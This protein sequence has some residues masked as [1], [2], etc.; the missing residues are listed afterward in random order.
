MARSKKFGSLFGN[1]SGTRTW[2]LIASLAILL[3]L[4]VYATMGIFSR[5]QADDYCYAWNGTA[6]PFMNAQATWYRTDSSRY[7]ATMVITLSEKLGRWTVPALPAFVLTLWLIGSTWLIHRLQRILNLAFPCI[8]SFVLAELC[9]Y[10]VLLLV[11]NLYQVLYWRPGLV[12]YL[13]PIVIL[14]YL[15]VFILALVSGPEVKWRYLKAPLAVL[16]FFINGGFSETIATIQIGMLVLAIVAVIIRR[17]P[18]PRN[19]TILLLGCALLGSLL[20][21]ATLYFSPATQ[22]R[23]G[24]VGAPPGLVDLIRMSFSNA[25]IFIYITLGEKAFQIVLLLL[26]S[27]L[28]GYVIFSTELTGSRLRATNLVSALFLTPFFTYLLIVF[29]CAPFAYGESTYPEARVLL[30]AMVFMVIMVI[31]EGLILGISL[32]L[33][34]QRSGENVPAGLRLVTLLLL[35]VISLFPLYST[36]KVLN[37]YPKFQQRAEAWDTRDAQIRSL[38]AKGQKDITVTAFNSYAGLLEIGPIPSNW[39]NGCAALYYGVHSI[40]AD[41]P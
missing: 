11:P 3:P 1:G 12:I 30:N 28:T 23:Q 32:G 24:L 31:M 22:M 27:L 21:M 41:L 34:H 29:V 40:T 9:I 10:F 38:A 26:T 18:E 20:A 19:W 6:R 5:Y 39:V 4:V 2:F 14:T 17:K 33:L 7:A 13:V 35:L 25:F 16:L 37:E 15:A 8:T 36:R